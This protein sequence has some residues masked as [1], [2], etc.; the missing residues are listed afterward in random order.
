M[1]IN[2]YK[3]D[4]LIAEKRPFRVQYCF[5]PS[6]E[7]IVFF[8]LGGGGG[9]FF[10]SGRSGLNFGGTQGN[11]GEGGKGF[12][13]GGVGGRSEHFNV[14][15]GFGGGGGSEGNLAGG[16]GGGYSGGSSG[17][18]LAHSCGGGGGSY[19]VGANQQNECCFNTAGHGNVTIT[20]L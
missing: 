19:N 18:G 6:N 20:K 7:S 11:G 8:F 17:V 15:G 13:Q 2:P 4:K 5:K 9:G 10:S 3:G 16:G 14:H 1:F 12:L